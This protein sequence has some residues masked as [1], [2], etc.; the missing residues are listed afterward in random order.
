MNVCFQYDFHPVGQGL[1][2]SGCL[3]ESQKPEPLFLWVYD[4]GSVTHQTPAYWQDQATKLKR[5]ARGKQK[6]DLLALSHFDKDHIDG[7]TELLGQFDVETL[8]IPYIP[9]WRRLVVAFSS[10]I[11]L[12]ELPMDYIVDPVAYLRGIRENAITRIII[13]PVSDGDGPPIPEGGRDFPE[14]PDGFEKPHFKAK[15]MESGK[16][17]DAGYEFGTSVTGIELLEKRVAINVFGLWEFCPY[18]APRPAQSPGFRA[19]VEAL[20]DG[21]LNTKATQTNRKDALAE[22][23]KEYHQEFGKGRDDAIE[24]N[25]ISLFLY[26]GPIYSSWVETKLLPIERTVPW[27]YPYRYPCYCRVHPHAPGYTDKCS[28]LYSGD[29]SLSN[30]PQFVHLSGYL[31]PERMDKLGVFQVNHHGAVGN[32]HDGLAGKIR[33]EFSVFSSDPARG[34]TN[35]PDAVVLRDFWPY[36][37]VQVN[38]LGVSYCGWLL[39]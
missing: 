39:L 30:D 9:L 34:Q 16:A 1:F 33:P 3:Y 35:H 28:I 29:G 12:S 2:A 11:A 17:G 36:S 22:L 21:L 19:K 23:K 4:C 18:N 31:K 27:A 38:T 14:T 7:V 20:R 13:V 6:I 10:G 26:A 15:K 37:P 24:L 8:L 32:W 5:F 25:I